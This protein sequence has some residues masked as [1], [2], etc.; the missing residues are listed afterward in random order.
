MRRKICWLDIN[1]SYSHSSLALPAI[2]A[3]CSNHFDIEWSV[4]S[5]TINSVVSNV[6]EELVEKKPD[7]IAY[8]AW[9]FTHEMLIK[10]LN[11]YKTLNP[12]V[13][14]IGGGAEYLGCNEEFLRNNP[15]INFVTRGEGE[16]LFYHWLGGDMSA[17][18]LC[19][20]D[21]NDHYVDNGIAKVKNFVA[22]VPPEESRL[23]DWSKPFVQIESARG[24]FNSCAFCV[25]GSDKPVRNIPIDTIRQRLDKVKQH[26]IRDIRVLDRTF[27]STDKRTIELLNLFREFSGD[28]NFHLEVHPALMTP[29]LRSELSAMPPST[30]HLEAGVQ[31][32]SQKVIDEVNRY[33]KIEDVIDGLR[34]LASLENM[35]V[36][37]DLIAGLPYYTLDMIYNDV[38]T[39]ASIG[40]HEI[41]LELLK[42]L[43]G[44]PLRNNK[45]IKYSSLPPYEVMQ[46]E[47]I[48]YGELQEARRLSRVIDF[49]YNS[50]NWR[51]TFCYLIE[52]DKK[53]L[54]KFTCHL[55]DI[56]IIDTPLSQE[57]RG[58]ILYDYCIENYPSAL[59]LLTIGWLK[60]GLSLKRGAGA[61]AKQYKDGIPEELN[62][63]GVN[64]R[65][66]NITIE[67]NEIWFTIDRSKS[68]T[69]PID[70]LIKKR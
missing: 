41:Q 51:E 22:L 50:V 6:V 13:V 19:Y 69:K 48:S 34:F 38:A 1:A 15:F 17:E 52:F 28:L 10:I 3:Q 4:V 66:Y 70:I 29:L 56:E 16:E 58:Q 49:Y 61:T 60:S 36:H 7:I 46:T 65:I 30:L 24:C 23:F 12:E 14:V 44:T 26:G 47:W 27:N 63:G 5:G 9:L 53:F 25:S 35:E 39:L 45:C 33:G 37:S 62:V 42:L 55:T 32:L 68:L 57:R 40:C 21:D 18:G 59:S 2:E 43:P 64:G 31:S 8:T 11:R 67:N 54:E 20:I